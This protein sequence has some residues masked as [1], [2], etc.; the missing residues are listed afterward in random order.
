MFYKESALSTSP[1]SPMVRALKSKFFLEKIEHKYAYLNGQPILFRLKDIPPN[2][3]GFSL[4]YNHD[5]N[6]GNETLIKNNKRRIIAV[7]ITS[8]T[9]LPLKDGDELLEVGH[10]NIFNFLFY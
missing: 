8:S 5:D 7:N 4:A 2:G 6:D 9:I 1:P 3:L 10:L